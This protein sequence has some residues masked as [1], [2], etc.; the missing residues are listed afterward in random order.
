M[1]RVISLYKKRSR[2]LTDIF[3][4]IFAFKDSR[5]SPQVKMLAVG[6]VAYALLPV[7]II[8]DYIPFA[9]FVDDLLLATVGIPLIMRMLPEPVLFD[10]R[11]KAEL[12]A[13]KAKRF[14]WVL[15]GIAVLWLGLL[16][17]GVYFIS[18]AAA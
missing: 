18:R 9:G 14:L 16:A 8:P 17:T 11:K 15:G 1:S 13:G 5:V 10:C 12:T 6:I 7:D 3:A 4:V 2:Y